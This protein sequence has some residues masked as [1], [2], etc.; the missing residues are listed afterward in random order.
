MSY[1]GNDEPM[2]RSKFCK[3]L[4][5]SLLYSC[6]IPVTK[7]FSRQS[8]EIILTDTTTIIALV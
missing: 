1:H 2:S 6:K 8:I 5:L 7:P 3:T 4:N